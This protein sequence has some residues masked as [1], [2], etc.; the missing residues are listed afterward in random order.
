[1]ARPISREILSYK[2]IVNTPTDFPSMPMD[3]PKYNGLETSG[4]T[5]GSRKQK[6]KYPLLLIVP[7]L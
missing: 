5:N 2:Y 7:K 3:K 1:M 6:K 4:S